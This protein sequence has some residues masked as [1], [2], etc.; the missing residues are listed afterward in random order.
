M[1]VINYKSLNKMEIMNLYYYTLKKRISK[2]WRRKPLSYGISQL[3]NQS[4][5]IK[6]KISTWQTTVI[7]LIQA[8]YINKY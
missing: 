5:K 1:T 8:R 7:I 2:N 4:G 3:I 6:F